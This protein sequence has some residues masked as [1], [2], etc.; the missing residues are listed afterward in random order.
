MQKS[1]FLF[2]IRDFRYY[3]LLEI[4]GVKFYLNWLLPTNPTSRNPVFS[5]MWRSKKTIYL[6]YTKSSIKYRI[7]IGAGYFIAHLIMF[8]MYEITSTGS[9]NTIDIISQT[10]VNVY[11]MLVQIYISM[12]CYRVL[13]K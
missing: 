8:I 9:T 2:M 3:K 13:K 6:D 7:G 5:F 1:K 11:P 4:L 10:L 12:R